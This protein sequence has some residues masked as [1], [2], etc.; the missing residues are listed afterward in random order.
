[1][2]TLNTAQKKA[3]R[4]HLVRK[5]VRARA[6]GLTG[7]ALMGIGAAVHRPVKLVPIAVG[8]I[9]VI[10]SFSLV[11]DESRMKKTL[12]IVLAGV[13]KDGMVKTEDGRTRKVTFLGSPREGMEVRVIVYADRSLAVA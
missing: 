7:A 10:R 4:T 6:I 1:M 5:Y 11:A 12:P 9:L 3:L 8:I 13:V 2:T